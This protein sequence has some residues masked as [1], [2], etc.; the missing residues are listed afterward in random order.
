M[1]ALLLAIALVGQPSTTGEW[2]DHLS[3]SQWT[4][5]GGDLRGSRWVFLELYYGKTLAGRS[6]HVIVQVTEMDLVSGRRIYK[7]QYWKGH[8]KVSVEDGVPRLVCRLTELHE[9]S[10]GDDKRDLQ[11]NPNFKAVDVTFVFT[12]TS[13]AERRKGAADLRVHFA[14]GEVKSLGWWKAGP[15]FAQDLFPLSK[16]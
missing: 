14:R 7:N 5:G 13:E 2:E 16:D 3:K 15:S 11:R 4:N 8:F 9:S 1:N 6:R 10:G 12:P